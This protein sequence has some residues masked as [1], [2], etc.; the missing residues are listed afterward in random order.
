ML[1]MDMFCNDFDGDELHIPPEDRVERR[2]CGRIDPFEELSEDDAEQCGGCQTPETIDECGCCFREFQ[3]RC[4]MCHLRFC[5][6]EQRCS[7]R[8]V[9]VTA[10]GRGF[11]Q[12]VC[13]ECVPF[14]CRRCNERPMTIVCPSRRCGGYCEECFEGHDN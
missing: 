6:R 8:V 10:G 12:S 7:T 1:N 13:E 5:G 14:T 11:L 3:D 2:L 9:A 4:E